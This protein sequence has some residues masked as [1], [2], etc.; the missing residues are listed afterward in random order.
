M[1]E[2]LEQAARMGGAPDEL[3]GP[4]CPDLLAEL[5]AWFIELDRARRHG[6]FGPEPLAYAD[7]EAWAR[8]TGRSPSPSEVAMIVDIDRLAFQV[9]AE[10]RK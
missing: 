2:H 3:I 1:R 8:L 7:I 10:A 6:G 5:W 4:R 9:R